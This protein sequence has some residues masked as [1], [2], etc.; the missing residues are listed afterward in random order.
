MGPEHAGSHAAEFLLPHFGPV[1]LQRRRSL[2]LSL[3]V[4]DTDRRD[5]DPDKQLWRPGS[6][7]Q[8]ALR[9][10]N[11]VRATL[12]ADAPGVSSVD[13]FAMLSA[14]R[15]AHLCGSDQTMSGRTGKRLLGR[16][17]ERVIAGK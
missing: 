17:A 16:M 5:A 13:N 12:S 1:L 9:R 10:R 7:G 2:R 15:R 14:G 3:A 4:G 8:G 11:T 6:A